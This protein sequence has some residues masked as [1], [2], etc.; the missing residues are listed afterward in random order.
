MSAKLKLMNKAAGKRAAAQKILD[1]VAADPIVRDMTP[2][3]K[4]QFDGLMAEVATIKTQVAQMATIEEGEAADVEA[5]R[6]DEAAVAQRSARRGLPIGDAPAIHDQKRPYSILRAVRSAVEGRRLDGVEGEVD[7]EISRRLGRSAKGFFLPLGSDPEI[8][9]LM[10]GGEKAEVRRAD[11]TTTTGTGAVFTLAELPLIDLLR[12]KL[13]VKQLGA[14]VL[15]GLKGAIAIPRQTGSATVY[16]LAEGSSATA[17]APTIDQVALTPKV[18]IALTNISRKFLLQ[19]SVDAEQFVRN[20]LAETMAREWDRVAIN[21]T[22]TTQPLG[23]LQNT[24]IQTLSAALQG[25]TNGAALTYAQVVAMESLVATANADTGKLAYLTSPSQR[26]K[27][28]FA[29]LI[30]ST[31]PVFIYGAG[32]PSFTNGSGTPSNPGQVGMINGYPAYAS[33]VVPSNLT[34]G[35]A[36]GT[37]SAIIF[38]NWSDL[39]IGSWEDAVDFLVNP[40]TLQASGA[41]TISLEMAIDVAERHNESFAIITDAL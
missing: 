28:K 14:T 12:N 27:L 17:S 40:Y 19:S 5:A 31:Y 7:Q 8:R 34:K 39:V 13:V 16:W 2:E 11:L 37:A 21:G 9:A 33:G 23:V 1:Q 4:T 10:A 24:A 32:D 18:A 6:A 20:D 29:P 22:G 41:V 15:T 35:T 36:S 26:G 38:A 30:G 25:G 3:E